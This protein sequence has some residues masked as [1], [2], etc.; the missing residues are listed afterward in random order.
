MLAIGTFGYRRNAIEEACKKCK[1]DEECTRIGFCRCKNKEKL[2]VNGKC[3]P[4]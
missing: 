1:E 2:M 3:M 4:G